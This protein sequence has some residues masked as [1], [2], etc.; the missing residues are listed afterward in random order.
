MQKSLKLMN[1]KLSTVISD[2]TGLSG[3]RK[4]S[5]I[6]AGNC[7]PEYL[8]SLAMSNCK[9]SKEEIAASLE[10]TW[11]ADLLFTLKQS[12]EAYDSSKVGLCEVKITEKKIAKLERALAKLRNA[13]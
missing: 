10:G 9:A 12:V 2:I 7:A 3:R 4:I 8:A 1:I 13:S 6:L 11:D 5:A